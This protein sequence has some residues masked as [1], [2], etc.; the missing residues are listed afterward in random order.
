MGD[1]V[2]KLA[3]SQRDIQDAETEVGFVIKQT[4]DKGINDSGVLSFR[5]AGDDERF[6]DLNTLVL[7]VDLRVLTRTGDDL[8]PKANVFLD[9]G[10]IYSLFSSCD[11]RFN[12]QVVSNMPCYPYTA[13]LCRYLGMSTDLRKGVWQ[14][15]DG[16]WSDTVFGKANIEMAD[17]MGQFDYQRSQVAGSRT[18][19]LTGRIYS[20]LLMSCR[21]YLPPNTVLGIDLRRAPDAF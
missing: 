4:L 21:Q 5:V 9:S 7:S 20:D 19:T 8:D 3:Y 1:S 14:E 15:L 16:T 2:D 17:D 13:A 10:G 11:V 12:G 18:L 6:T